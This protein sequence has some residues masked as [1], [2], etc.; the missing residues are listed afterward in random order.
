VTGRVILVVGLR[1]LCRVSLRVALMVF[2][3]QCVKGVVNHLDRSED[4]ISTSCNDANGNW[5]EV[6]S[7]GYSV[8][9]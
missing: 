2:A 4:G 5:V 8:E 3:C 6:S 7:I 1:V 9:L